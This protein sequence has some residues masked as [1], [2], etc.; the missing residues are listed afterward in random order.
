MNK[1]FVFLKIIR[2]INALMAGFTIFLGYWIGKSPYSLPAL[3]GFILAASS[4]VGFGNIINDIIDIKTD[5]IAHPNRP[6]PRGIIT[7]HSALL[8][9]I[10]LALLA[11][12]CSFPWS[13]IHGI[14]TVVPLVF[15]LVYALFFKGTPLIG[16]IVVSLMVGYTI[17][18]GAL[19]G[20]TVNHVFLPAFL[21]FLLNLCREI[22]KDI[23]DF[24]GDNAAGITT[25]A[26]LSPTVNNNILKAVNALYVCLLPIPLILGHFKTAYLLLS[27]FITIPLHL[28]WSIF[29]FKTNW[30]DRS[31]TISSLLKAEM[32]SGLLALSIDRLIFPF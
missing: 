26:H 8:Y 28:S 11:L 13:I 30:T 27:L 15:L 22:I 6:L 4:S 9:A 16:N 20:K 1:I 21:A 32:F 5:V 29:L 12:S 24:E 10:V 23:Q 3:T 25:T 18:Y 31:S 2:P 19:L 7:T 14:G 17:I